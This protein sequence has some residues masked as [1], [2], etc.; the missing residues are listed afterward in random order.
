MDVMVMAEAPKLK[1]YM[2]S[3]VRNIAQALSL[4][5]TDV[6]IKAGTNE[7]LGFVGR[8]EGIAVEAVALL[9]QKE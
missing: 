7:R 9:E 5:T 2:E 1:N 8:G 4:E 6:S 3:M